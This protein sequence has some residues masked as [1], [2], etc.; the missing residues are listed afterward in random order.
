V[1]N[2]KAVLFDLD[3]TLINSEH[4]YF[5]NWQPILLENYNLKIDFDEWL[6]YFAGHTLVRNVGFLKEKWGIETT[7]EFMWTQ[8]RA[9]YAKSDMTRI[10]LMPYAREILSELSHAGKRIALVT[11]SYQTTV[12][13]VLG[14]HG[15][16]DYFEF[17]VTREKV[18][19]AK[20]NPEPYLQAIETLS[21]QASDVVAVED[22][23]TGLKA[24][25]AA[26]LICIAVSEQ[27]VEIPRLA[28]APYLVQ[29]L[30]SV[31]EI[32]LED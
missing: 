30:K 12:D 17:F 9:N 13:K 21:L 32:L 25:T 19:N 23:S 24:A 16:L 31:R 10:E 22:T 1:K 20:P 5:K 8:T 14:H 27:K 28:D 11:S 29:D 26:G 3:G 2:V 15:L 7:E 6:E 4:F 18:E